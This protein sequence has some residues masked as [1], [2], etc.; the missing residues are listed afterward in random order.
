M[1]ENKSIFRMFDPD[2]PDFKGIKTWHNSKPLSI[3]EF[4]GKVVLIDFF[5]YSCS[6]CVNTFPNV[7]MML[8][9]Y[10]D[11]GLVVI[12][13]QTP[14][15]EFEKDDANVAKALEKYG[16][17]YPVANDADNVTWR[18]YGGQ[19]WPR[20]ALVNGRGKVVFQ[21][22][23]EGGEHELE[24]KIIDLL[25]EI[26][27]K[28]EFMIEKDRE[29][30]R[31]DRAKVADYV[32]RKTP[33]TYLGWERGR[34]GNGAACVP[35][36]CSNF[37]DHDRHADHEVY[38]S[39]EWVQ[40]KESARK[41]GDAEGYLAIRYTARRANAVMRPYLGKRHRVHVLLDGKP[42][43]RSNAGRDV[44]IDQTGSFV[45][46]ERPD[47]YELVETEAVGTHELRL[48]SDSDEFC[49]HALTFS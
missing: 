31:E 26:G 8:D 33:E 45:H 36:S 44:K 32:K 24:L 3:R 29:L 15:F 23:G 18:S 5:T 46:V 14:E 9:K 49:V 25:H 4:H 1:P 34:I 21:Q 39:G 7:R 17:D 12:G 6:N 28:G 13:V 16:I 35:G 27:V 30:T 11:R 38:L 10:K 19:Y 22:V 40:E 42:L 37:V 41:E 47:M 43:D 20:R 2:A 48:V